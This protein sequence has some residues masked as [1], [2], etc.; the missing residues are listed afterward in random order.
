M[1]NGINANHVGRLTET[2]P[3]PS[4][5]PKLEQAHFNQNVYVNHHQDRAVDLN[6]VAFSLRHDDV[7]RAPT[8]GFGPYG[9]VGAVAAASKCFVPNNIPVI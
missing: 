5:T 1:L 4:S 7:V 2:Q 6:P 8:D 3:T 9:A